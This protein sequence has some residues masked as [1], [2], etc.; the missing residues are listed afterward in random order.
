MTVQVIAMP[1]TAVQTAR[2][3]I[4]AI[5]QEKIRSAF[6]A[7]QIAWSAQMK[8]TANYAMKDIPL[9]IDNAKKF[10][11]LLI[12]KVMNSICLYDLY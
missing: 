12:D 10:N 9:K 6:D 4:W 8:M 5:S 7:L 2:L 1:A 3:A 11:R